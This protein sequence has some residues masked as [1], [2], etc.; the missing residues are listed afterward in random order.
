MH[1]NG[2]LVTFGPLEQGELPAGIEVVG[3]VPEN[4]HRF[5]KKGNRLFMM[6]CVGTFWEIEGDFAALTLEEISYD[7]ERAADRSTG[8]WL[9]PSCN[10]K[11]V[12]RRPNVR[13]YWR[14][15]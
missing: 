9:A 13:S 12:S 10:P 14:R 5:G 15:A 11:H 1:V 3:E 4:N 8:E 6:D 2:D 7:F